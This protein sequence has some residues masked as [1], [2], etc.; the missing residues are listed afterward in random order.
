MISSVFSSTGPDGRGS[1]TCEVEMENLV[2]SLL[3]PCV[4]DIKVGTRLYGDDATPEK[5]RKM[6]DKA[7]RC[8]SSTL[9][10]RLVGFKC[11]TYKRELICVGSAEGRNVQ[12]R[13]GFL[14]YLR[15]FLESG[16]PLRV[17][18]LASFFIQRVRRLV[19]LFE[20]QDVGAFFGSSLLLSFDAHPSDSQNSKADLRMIDFAHVR[21]QCCNFQKDEGYLR[22][23]RSLLSML[24]EFQRNDDSTATTSEC[25]DSVP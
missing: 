6:I 17:A 9:G 24:D 16:G 21:F 20:S 22:G 14:E 7:N 1:S 10:V 2:Y 4:M 23:L 25:S 15:L 13:D 19:D 18:S 12:T 8:T 11:A 5:Q 3:R